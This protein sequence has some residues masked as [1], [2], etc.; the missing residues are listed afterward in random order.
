VNTLVGIDVQSI[1]EVATS[2]TSFG[3]RYTRRL[4]TSGEIEIYGKSSA[5]AP[6]YFAACFAAKEAVL[7]ILDV[8]D[9]V[10]SWKSITVRPTASGKAEIVLDDTAADLAHRQ[11][12][13]DISLD[14]SHGAGFVI[15]TVIAQARDLPR[16][17][18]P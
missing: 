12:I 11:G 1:D 18:R 15:A 7:K 5:T 3:S 6:R 14:V 10:P 4:F 16:G 8:R 9:N 13:E 17:D 2:L